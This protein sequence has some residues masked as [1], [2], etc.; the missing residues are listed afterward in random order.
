MPKDLNINVGDT[1]TW[2][3]NHSTLHTA[4]K[5]SGPGD[6]FET[7]D[8][9]TF[10]GTSAPVTFNTPGTMHYRC[11]RHTNMTGTIQVT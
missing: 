4:T 11:D 5:T 3:N 7:G 2:K 8:I 6:H 9:S 1:V 10:G